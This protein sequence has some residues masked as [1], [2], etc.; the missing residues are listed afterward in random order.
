M[1]AVQGNNSKRRSVCISREASGKHPIDNGAHKNLSGKFEKSATP[2][3][4]TNVNVFVQ[5]QSNYMYYNSFLVKPQVATSKPASTYTKLLN[6]KVRPGDKDLFNH[7]KSSMDQPK[8]NLLNEDKKIIKRATVVV[9]KYSYFT[10]VGFLPNNPYKPNQD[11]FMVNPKLNGDSK[12]HL[13]AVAD[14]HGMN[15]IR[16][17]WKRSIVYNQNQSTMLLCDQVF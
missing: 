2:V 7:H 1:R 17:I 5:P 15:I 10:R 8:I 9:K 16:A 6:F 12:T 14:G 13:F 11:S 4:L 3:N